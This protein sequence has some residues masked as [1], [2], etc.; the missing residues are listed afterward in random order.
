MVLPRGGSTVVPGGTGVA[1]GG[2]GLL[3]G[4]FFVWWYNPPACSSPFFSQWGVPAT[5]SP[6]FVAVPDVTLA[7]VRGA[8]PTPPD[9]VTTTAPAVLPIPV[10]TTDRLRVTPGSTLPSPFASGVFV[11][12]GG[13]LD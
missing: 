6:S 12:R 3:N 9:S 7:R 2:R 4:T 5:V 11:S 1:P 13:Y 8:T 10:T